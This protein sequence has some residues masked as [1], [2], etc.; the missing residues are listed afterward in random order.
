MKERRLNE[1][2]GVLL[3]AAGLMVLS[4]LLRFDPLD[5]G[6]Y[7]SNPN[8]PPKNLLGIFGAY[9]GWLVVFLFGRFISFFIP[10]IILF[11]GIKTFRQKTLYLN[12]PQITGI[13]I[14]LVSLSSLIGMFNLTNEYARFYASGFLGAVSSEFVSR[15]FNRLGSFIIFITLIILCTALV[16]EVLISHL[17]IKIADKFKSLLNLVI[18]FKRQRTIKLKSTAY[19][20][21]SQATAMQPV[22]VK[23]QEAVKPAPEIIKPNIQIKAKPVHT[24]IKVKQQELKIGDYRLPSLD[25]LDSPPPLQARQIK[26]DL[27]T[28]ARILE[29]TLEDFGIQAKVMD[30]ERGPV[31]TRYELEPAP[32][33]KLNRI[34]ALG[35]DIAL[36]LKAQSVRIIAPIPGKGRVGV[37]VPNTQ[38]T[39]VYLKEVLAT[40]EYQKAK[41][42]L[43]LAL[44]KDITGQP[45]IA[46]L[47]QMPHLLIAGTTG[48]GK[49]VCVNSLILSLLFKSSPND[50]K[51]VMVDPKM[52][53]LMPFNG[54]PHL[55]CPVVTDAKK[56][57]AALNWVVNEMEERYQ[58]LAKVGARN[59]ESYNEK[60]EK[61]PYIIV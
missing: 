23:R 47:D 25:L 34:V 29:D 33:V 50:L 9:L 7:T 40:N 49:T 44:G 28:N 56:A 54:L 31:I 59:I 36:S 10:I 32:G 19:E 15:Y 21:P 13:F 24:E 12:M 37:E 26:E 60:Q 61:I 45:I 16:L 51:F 5:L 48:S 18:S 27:E 20:R 38:S 52:V 43:T 35:D 6:F 14:L 11:L 58:L 30:I 39:F 53:E 46:D 17:F 4:S 1:I 42:V 55:L 41:T 3:I 8:V 57:S 22:A 2:K